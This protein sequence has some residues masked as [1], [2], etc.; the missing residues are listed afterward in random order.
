MIDFRVCT[1]QSPSPAFTASL[2]RI[3]RLRT[4]LA[5]PIGDFVWEQL[6]AHRKTGSSTAATPALSPVS[7][8]ASDSST[9]SAARPG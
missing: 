2:A 9:L 8:M 4:A 7:G 5:L 1:Q 6:S 3:T